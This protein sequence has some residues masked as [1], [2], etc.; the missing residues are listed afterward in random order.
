M[1]EDRRAADI[2]RL[3]AAVRQTMAKVAICWAATPAANGDVSVRVVE[4]IGVAPDEEWTIFFATSA[5]SRK[6]KEIKRA[7]RLMLGYQHHPDRSYV[8]L[9]GRAALTVERSVIRAHWREP[10]RVYFPGGPDDANL[11]IVRLIVDRI[12]L[13][14]PGV[15]PE[16]FGSGHVTVAREA[17]GAWT[18]AA[19]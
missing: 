2:E 6:A 19:N 8:A 10:W 7:G 5:R 13:C 9:Y 17:A 3:L 12:E 14:V 18:I 16:P 4:P 15:A 1:L 11:V